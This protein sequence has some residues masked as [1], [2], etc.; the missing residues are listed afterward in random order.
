MSPSCEHSRWNRNCFTRGIARGVTTGRWPACKLVFPRKYPLL[1]LLLLAILSLAIASAPAAAADWTSQTSNTLNHLFGVSFTD[2]THGWA[3][4][5]LGT[6]RATPDAG[7]TWNTQNSGS[8]ST[9]RDVACDNDN[10]H[11]WA[12]GDLGTIRATAD[13]GAT[14]WGAQNAG[15]ITTLYG[16]YCNADGLHCWAVGDLGTI[17]V[18]ADGGATAWTGQTSG[19]L[20]TQLQGIACPS[21]TNCFAVGS[22]GAIIATTDGGTNWGPQTSG[23]L[24]TLN[25]VS[26][27]STS[28]CWAVG[29]GGTILATT[30]GG[31]TWTPQSSNTINILNDVSAV[32]TT[33]ATVAGYSGTIRSTTDGG[34]TWATDAGAGLTTLSGIDMV[35]ATHGWTVGSGGAI[36][37]TGAGTPAAPRVYHWTWYDSF[38]LRNWVLLGNA[39]SESTN[40]E[41]DLEIAGVARDP[42]NL[43]LGQGV[44]S[45]GNT[46]TP[47]YAGL[48]GGP[49]I[50]TSQTGE[51][52]IVSQRSLFGNSFEEVLG[53]ESTSL[54]DHFFWTWYDQLSPGY[55]NWVLVANPGA[56]TA[57]YQIRIAG[58]PVAQGAL[59]AGTMVTPEFP[60]MMGGPVEV[61]AWT[62]AVGGSTPANVMA[63]Q[64]VTS[65]FS[66]AFNEVPG[67]TSLSSD[68]LWTWYDASVPG[69]RNWVLVAN[70]SA[71]DTIHYRITIAGTVRAEGDLTPGSR[72]YPEFPGLMA[73][74]VEVK[75]WI[76]GGSDSNPADARF[77]IASQRTTWG[78][79][80]EEVPGY[81]AVA[82]LGASYHWTWYDAAAAGVR[83]WVLVANPGASPVHYVIKVGGVTRYEGDLAS[84]GRATPEFPGLMGGPVEVTST[85]GPVMAS[86]R[87]LWNGYFNEVL[88]TVLS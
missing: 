71:T 66:T 79:S 63:S 69:N 1:L 78:P 62:D 6:I 59:A 23:T 67:I 37:E 56:S 4:G 13:G 87:V 12:V 5:S 41:Y 36:F 18:T 2:T 48:I 73:G 75:S 65:N 19:V 17:R 30:N 49:V 15:T 33:H 40:R 16:V 77:S 31:T 85:G 54:S 70:P 8:L 29:T 3:V 20:L 86:Q 72:V 57:Y 44:V 45:P 7:A 53:V 24:N 14:A 32:D 47:Y 60:G 21:L 64:R 68:Y 35:D 46:L 84:G 50:A 38:Y 34:T 88:G 82:A 61:Q 55:R 39:S 22:G 26:C 11:C 52:G 51:S 25:A 27:A 9:L 42:G 76:Q 43:G 10:L 80:F 28:T 58:N 83:N 74:P 81:D